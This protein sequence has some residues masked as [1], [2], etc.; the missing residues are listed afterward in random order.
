MPLV[1]NGTGTDF[2]YLITVPTAGLYE[3]TLTMT[4]ASAVLRVDVND[5]QSS[6]L[7]L[8]STESRDYETLVNLEDGKNVVTISGVNG[9]NKKQYH[10]DGA[11]IRHAN[12]PAGMEVPVLPGAVITWKQGRGRVVLDGTEWDSNTQN[13]ARGAR[14][15]SALFSALGVAFTVQH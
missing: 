2:T 4:G 8:G 11:A 5:I 9:S 14:Y 3:L 6:W 1:A 12:Y 13:A 10:I 15:A 7:Q